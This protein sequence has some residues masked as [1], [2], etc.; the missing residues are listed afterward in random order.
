MAKG[1]GI[2]LNGILA[3]PDYTQPVVLSSGV[4]QAFDTPTGMAIAAF[5]MN[6]DFWVKYGSTGA[7]VPSTSSTAGSSSPELNPTMRF[8]GSTL[9]CTGLSIVSD[10]AAK[11]S[12][13]WYKAA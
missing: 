9:S 13:N 2:A 11:G 3:T 12:I 6:N 4:G 1:S 8:V 7:T 5:S 10:F